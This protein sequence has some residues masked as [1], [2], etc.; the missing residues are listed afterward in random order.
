MFQDAD[1][2]FKLRS[3][4]STPF[5]SCFHRVFGIPHFRGS[6]THFQFSRFMVWHLILRIHFIWTKPGSGFCQCG[7]G[8]HCLQVVCRWHV[9]FIDICLVP[10]HMV[11][12]VKKR[13]T[14]NTLVH[15]KSQSV[16]LPRHCLLPVSSRG[17]SSVIFRHESPTEA[18]GTYP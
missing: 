3:D 17:Y 18:A 6:F 2:S 1:D 9:L 13:L 4:L 10:L 5:F 11:G 15:R 7:V 16:V 12:C 8:L 14:R